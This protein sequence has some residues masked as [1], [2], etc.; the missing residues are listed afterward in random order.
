MLTPRDFEAQWVTSFDSDDTVAIGMQLNNG[1]S[2]TTVPLCIIVGNATQFDCKAA[3]P[4]QI[5]KGDLYKLVLGASGLEGNEQATLRLLLVSRLSAEPC[6]PC[7]AA[8][9]RALRSVLGRQQLRLLL[10]LL[11]ACSRCLSPSCTS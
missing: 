3:G 2:L 1:S 7:K 6:F 8:L 5:A 10:A 9:F 4:V 11:S